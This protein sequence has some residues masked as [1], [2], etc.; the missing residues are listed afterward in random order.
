MNIQEAII[1][2]VASE[3]TKRP[4]YKIETISTARHS[5]TRK[6]APERYRQFVLSGEYLG[7]PFVIRTHE[8]HLNVLMILGTITGKDDDSLNFAY[9]DPQLVTKLR[10]K[11]QSYEE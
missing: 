1:H 10:E 6:P 8:D 11:I 7:K 5:Y 9:S 2:G 4:G 3:L